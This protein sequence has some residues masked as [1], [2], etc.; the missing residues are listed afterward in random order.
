MYSLMQQRN[1]G[2]SRS[3]RFVCCALLVI[4]TGNTIGIDLLRVKDAY[5]QSIIMDPPPGVLLSASSTAACPLLKAISI[6]PIDPLKIDFLVDAGE[7]PNFNEEGSQRLIKY[8][9]AFLTIPEKDLWVNLSP[10]EPDRIVNPVLGGTAVGEDLLR[11]DYLLKQMAASMTFPD[12]EPGKSFWE[13]VR[14]KIRNKYGEVD[15]PLDTFSKVWVVPQKAVVYEQKGMAFIAESRLKV[16]LDQDYLTLKKTAAEDKVSVHA[17]KEITGLYLMIA[18]DII[19]P[20]LERE[21]NEGHYFSQLRQMFNS[22]VLAIWFKKKLQKH[23]VNQIYSNKK[24][25][26]GIQIQDKEIAQKIYAQYMVALKKG[27]YDIIREDYDTDQQEVVP[28]HYFS[29]GFS[30]ED[31]AERT[32]IMPV[33][34][35]TRPELVSLMNR[36]GKNIFR[37]T[38]SLVPR[39]M[40]RKSLLGLAFA[41]GLFLSSMSGLGIQGAGQGAF[42]VPV[43]STHMVQVAQNNGGPRNVISL[44]DV[45]RKIISRGDPILEEDQ[46]YFSFMNGFLTIDDVRD[47]QGKENPLTGQAYDFDADAI[48]RNWD[49]IFSSSTMGW[50]QEAIVIVA[51]HKMGI[52]ED[53]D[54]GPQTRGA[55]GSLMTGTAVV[56]T[57]SAAAKSDVKVKVPSVEKNS[58]VSKAKEVKTSIGVKSPSLVR[59]VSVVNKDFVKSKPVTITMAA[60]NT[61]ESAVSGSG[62]PPRPPLPPPKKVV[63]SPYVAPVKTVAPVSAPVIVKQSSTTASSFSSTSGTFTISKQVG[64][65]PDERTMVAQTTG[66]VSG[67]NRGA[68]GYQSGAV[69]FNIEEDDVLEQSETNDELLKI[70]GAKLNRSLELNANGNMPAVKVRAV[71]GQVAQRNQVKARL[72]N[73]RRLF[74]VRAP[75]RLLIKNMRIYNNTPVKKG[76]EMFEYIDQDRVR[77]TVEMPYNKAFFGYFGRFEIDGQQVRRILNVAVDPDPTHNLARVTFLV[78]PSAPISNSRNAHLNLEILPPVLSANAPVINA[79]GWAISSVPA[80]AELLVPSPVDGTAQYFV[81]LGQTVKKGQLMVI[82]EGSASEE[83]KSTLKAYEAVKSQLEMSAPRDG[84]QHFSNDQM[85]ELE[86]KAAA[87]GAKLKALRKQV[88]RTRVTAPANGIVTSISAM[89][90]S[91]FA[92]A[93]EMLRIK[94]SEVPLGSLYDMNN[95][96]QLPDNI[97]LQFNDPIVLMTPWGEYVPARVK[98]VNTMPMGQTMRLSGVQTVEIL[99]EDINNVL[100]PNLPVK[101]IVPTDEDKDLVLAMF[102]SAARSVSYGAEPAVN[103]GRSGGGTAQIRVSTQQQFANA[104]IMPTS[105]PLLPLKNAAPVS[106]SFD[107]LSLPKGQVVSMKELSTRTANNFLINGKAELEVQE[108]RAKEK[109]ANPSSFNLKFG[110]VSNNGKLGVSGGLGLVFNGIQGGLTTGNIYGALSPIVSTL[111]GELVKVITG[112]PQKLKALQVKKTEAL[113]YVMGDLVSRNIQHA[114]DLD[115]QV[116][117]AQWHIDHLQALLNDLN[118]ALAVVEANEKVGNVVTAEK[119]ALHAKIKASRNNLSK[120]QDDLVAWTFEA[121]FYH[122]LESGTKFSPEFPWNGD[123]PGMSQSELDALSSTL[124]GDK[125]PNFKLKEAK[126]MIEGMAMTIKLNKLGALPEVNVNGLFLTQDISNTAVDPYSGSTYKTSASQSGA[127]GAV[128]VNIPIYNSKNQALKDIGP[129][130]MNK[131]VNDQQRIRAEVGS[132]LTQVAASINSLSQQIKEG[133]ED[134]LKAIKSWKN[135][136]SRP[137]LY[138]PYEQVAAR[139]EIARTAQALYDLK[140]KYFKAES[141]LTQMQ[142]LDYGTTRVLASVQ[143]SSIGQ[144]VV[145]AV[146][147]AVNPGY[148]GPSASAFK[149][150]SSPLASSSS[151]FGTGFHAAPPITGMAALSVTYSAPAVVQGSSTQPVSSGQVSGMSAGHVNYSSS[152]KTISSAVM[153]A[154]M[155]GGQNQGQDE[156]DVLLD[157]LMHDPNII[158]RTQTL[159]FFMKERQNDGKF[160]VVAQKAVLNSPFPDVVQRLFMNMSKTNGSE[161]RFFVHT[162]DQAISKNNMAL[163]RLGFQALNDLFIQD[164]TV[165]RHWTE[166]SYSEGGDADFMKMTPQ[167]ARRVLLTFLAFAPDDWVGKE[168]FLQSNYWSTRQLAGIHNDLLGAKEPAAAKLAPIIRKE[169]I[170]RKFE[171]SVPDFFNKGAFR[172]LGGLGV[173]EGDIYD[174]HMRD[175]FKDMNT[176]FFTA[177]PENRDMEGFVDKDLLRGAEKEADRE[178]SSGDPENKGTASPL[179]ELK[180]LSL[181]STDMLTY[182]DALGTDAQTEYINGTGLSELAR[183]LASPTFQRGVVLDKLMEK[184][185]GR[186]LAW[187]EYVHSSDND[188]LSLVE[189]RTWEALLRADVQ[190]MPDP[191]SMSI[192]REGMIKMYGRTGQDW[193]LNIR[194]KTF[195]FGELHAATDPRPNGADM[196]KAQI[197]AMAIGIALDLVESRIEY[198]PQLDFWNNSKFGTAETALIKDMRLKIA[199]ETDPMKIITHFE[200]FNPVNS[201]QKSLKREIEKKMKSLE[202]SILKNDQNVSNTPSSIWYAFWALFAAGAFIAH[203]FVQKKFFR[204]YGKVD[205]LVV[206]L[207]KDVIRVKRKTTSWKEKVARMFLIPGAL[208]TSAGLTFTIIPEDGFN[209]SARKRLVKVQNIVKS[210]NEDEGVDPQGVIH[211]INEALNQYDHV[212][213]SMP[214]VPELMGRGSEDGEIRNGKY[215]KTFFHLYLSITELRNAL[216]HYQDSHSGFDSRQTEM[217]FDDKARLLDMQTYLEDYLELFESRGSVDKLMGYKGSD[218][219]FIEKSKVYPFMRYGIKYTDQ[220]GIST[221]RIYEL[222]PEIRIKGNK[223]MPGIYNEDEDL[224]GRSKKILEDMIAE[225]ETLHSLTS[226]A[227]ARADLWRRWR[228][229]LFLYAPPIFLGLGFFARFLGLPLLGNGLIVMTILGAIAKFGSF[230]WAQYVITHPEWLKD[231]KAINNKL[232]ENFDKKN[233]DPLTSNGNGAKGMDKVVKRSV[234]EGKAALNEQVNG[235]GAPSVDMVI[236]I[237]ED[238][239]YVDEVNKY[240]DISRGV[241]TRDSVPMVIAPSAKGSGNVELR[242]L[243]FMR[244]KL[245]DPDFLARYPH[246]RGKPWQDVR[247]MFVFHGMNKFHDNRVL[248]WALINGYRLAAKLKKDDPF[249][250]GGQITVYSRDAYFGPMLEFTADKD[251]NVQA[252]WVNEKE[253]ETLGLLKMDPDGQTNAVAEIHEKMIVSDIERKGREPMY[254]DHELIYLNTRFDL[255]R[256]KLKQFPALSG[257]MF[258][259]AK[260]V[261][262]LGKVLDKLEQD[263]DLWNS[264]PL[265]HMTNDIINPLI[266][267]EDRLL[268]AYLEKRISQPDVYE[269]NG[270]DHKEL[271]DEQNAARKRYLLYYDLFLEA[272][273]DFRGDIEAGAILPN[274]S[275]AKV[276]HIKFR[277]QM[278]DISLQLKQA[279]LDKSEEVAAPEEPDSAAL[280]ENGGL[281]L[282]GV[283]DIV[284]F[285]GIL[286][287]VDIGL[288]IFSPE[289]SQQFLQL[290][291]GFDFRITAFQPLEDPGLFLLP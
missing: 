158:T 270:F 186:I 94:P 191:E 130:N 200:D 17:E 63:S 143:S 206:S 259:N 173:S 145:E 250:K 273:K 256:K 28:R 124:L 176:R 54:I 235:S 93:D 33:W 253:L 228:G 254:V 98:N 213:R 68:N 99:A 249:S 5:A 126:A 167:D 287:P 178:I 31:A 201:T 125:T 3:F 278:E 136:A 146:Q 148:G 66:Y 103:G 288:Q 154:M 202:E 168:R 114:Q 162:I 65:V 139:E 50:M 122:G 260:T 101:V 233:G 245:K 232:D 198:T 266:L 39:G 221:K 230:W 257:L 157:I 29:G 225:A 185:D 97:S 196:V 290:F 121:N 106:V 113:T 181:E 71:E 195:T 105:M 112:E 285:K 81:K 149:Y 26:S 184:P 193:P 59:P 209:N 166:A 279:G 96:I 197:K 72:D 57:T 127:N 274:Y 267:P 229:R 76:T 286:T 182:F 214:Y 90:V 48:E 45:S 192:L 16:L 223:L 227:A 117:N 188:L 234:D 262:I 74:T 12:V 60:S 237:P 89:S 53:G 20:E 41:G 217:L 87:L 275:S 224:L 34:S 8:F 42:H 123:F 119:D 175:I 211:D 86:E 40:S 38:V 144:D 219:H 58:S 115:I 79:K 44:E 160:M 147:D 36:F 169:L 265:L 85:D 80:S 135:M 131:F 7:H 52:V 289:S 91:S 116:G 133:N 77:L 51:Q 248:D 150:G 32:E 37:F 118:K 272:R 231:M 243:Q 171:E 177:S 14:S 205:D 251:I 283:S 155:A 165:L 220:I 161:P 128:N 240:V 84:V 152:P 246:L 187:R 109:F 189:S 142:L 120:W 95:T 141:R 11:Q 92:F 30:F 199:G 207:R 183:I 88:R 264:L 204:K 13:Q 216:D 2:W 172:N 180:D 241:M 291:R 27:V 55:L 104:V 218:D 10:S 4:Y 263:P 21:V 102:N 132:E 268:K 282:T 111:V 35:L 1:S 284:D 64:L 247:A 239:D 276:E 100:Q 47:I 252:D 56:K 212:I 25:T 244:T 62:G 156:Y 129:I 170:R 151:S 159:D 75:S 78:E 70:S 210:W 194:L 61:V 208:G 49:K 226:A 277:D 261:S 255:K 43:D 222:I 69:M 164:T 6:D 24:K 134:Y 280:P 137:D 174:A 258:F 110:I 163:A 203:G 19:I 107:V 281:D 236:V 46:K 271:I 269:H 242:A 67:L 179:Y 73:Q 18:R 190:S 15:L 83:Y 153:W 140:A 238:L 22:L 108:S 138:S 9:L 82:V 215:M 23:I